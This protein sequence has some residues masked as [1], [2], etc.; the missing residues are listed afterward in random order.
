M[1]IRL[2]RFAF[3]EGDARRSTRRASGTFDVYHQ[4]GFV[5]TSILAKKLGELHI[6]GGA[7]E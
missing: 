6:K 5:V 4:N 3:K 2:P 7:K 1:L